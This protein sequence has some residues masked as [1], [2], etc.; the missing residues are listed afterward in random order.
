MFVSSGRVCVQ[1]YIKFI[2][3]SSLPRILLEIFNLSKVDPLN[4]KLLL[5]MNNLEYGSPKLWMFCLNCLYNIA[6]LRTEMIHKMSCNKCDVKE[7]QLHNIKVQERPHQSY[8]NCCVYAMMELA[9]K[10]QRIHLLTK[11]CIGTEWSSD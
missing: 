4:R 5:K 6:V 8:C 7:F 11:I 1:F 9:V 3:T 10:S 2:L